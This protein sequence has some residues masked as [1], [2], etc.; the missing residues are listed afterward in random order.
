MLLLLGNGGG[1]PLASGRSWGGGGAAP[2]PPPPPSAPAPHSIDRDLLI[3]LR[4]ARRAKQSLV[5]RAPRHVVAFDEHARRSVDIPWVVGG[6]L[7]GGGV[8]G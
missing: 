7:K 1:E 2:P 6:W 5:A 3:R 4:E 8:E